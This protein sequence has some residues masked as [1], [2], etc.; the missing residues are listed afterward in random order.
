[1][2]VSISTTGTAEEPASDLG[3]LLHKHPDKVQ[4]FATAHGSAHVFYPESGER[5]CTAALLLEVDP[6]ALLR[7]G[8]GKGRSGSPDLALAQY[9]NDRPYA[10]S[11]LLAVALRTVYRSAMKGEC[12]HRPELPGRA[13]PLRIALPAVPV[14]G[15]DGPAL[16]E[17]LFAPL[18]WQVD[19]RPLP[20]DE[21]FPEWGDS[22]YV[23]LELTGTLRLSDALQHLYVLLPVLDGA[24]H[25]WVAPD[26]VDKL[27]AAGQGWLAD[28]PERALIVRRYLSRRWS[29]TRLATER[30]ALARLAEADDREAEEIDN[31]VPDV[32]ENPDAGDTEDTAEAP[33]AQGTP[34]APDATEEVN[35]AGAAEQA[36]Q[37]EQAESA[38]ATGTGEAT[39]TTE[40]DRERGGPL[41]GQRRTA[42]LAALART[43]A[44]RV[45]DLGCGQGELV[46][47][48]LKEPRVTE[49]LGVDVSS[50]ALTTAAR[51]LRLD[52]L[53]ERQARRVK[54]VQGALTYTDARLKGYDAAVLCEV[55]EHL[56]LPR[57][58][59]LEYAVFGAARPAAVV[60]TTP[61]AEYN[62]R[63]ETLPAGRMRHDDHRF[64]WS[65]A[66]FAAWTRRVAEAYGYT[67][68]LEPVGPL[69]PEVGAPT[70]LAHFRLAP[71]APEA[72]DIP[73]A[74]ETPAAPGA[75][76]VPSND[77]APEGSAHR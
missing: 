35:A 73:E 1:M 25:Y 18:G 37:A 15:A 47:A 52:R 11:S 7:Q 46:G 31:A 64:E 2:F 50:R 66:E 38:E 44:A 33:G 14:A 72:P 29:L 26:E 4:R 34:G 12:A 6:A 57:L 55:I 51:R 71:E 61:N 74:L 56:D 23:R 36:E 48:L 45:L 24:K 49:V 60:V 20:L 10:A 19:A 3:F 62:V 17:R 59:A 75:A 67:V 53:P 43:G 27:L 42:I 13:R 54:L 9:V 21:S 16:V 41:A 70:Q 77:P 40:A 32:P 76:T 63:W 8:R 30:L 68:D 65:R 39:E 22:R 69:D 58:P 28:H 5:A